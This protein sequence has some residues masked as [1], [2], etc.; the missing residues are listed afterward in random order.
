V[1]ESML[2][3]LILSKIWGPMCEAVTT[4]MPAQAPLNFLVIS[5]SE[6]G[7]FR[8]LS[9]SVPFAPLPIN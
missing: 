2:N 9:A 1:P 5:Q 3:E 7:S 4:Y 6:Y 8:G